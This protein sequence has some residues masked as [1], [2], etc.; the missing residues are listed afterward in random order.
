ML[1]K[2]YLKEVASSIDLINDYSSEMQIGILVEACNHL[3]KIISFRDNYFVAVQKILFGFES[4][5]RSAFYG[6]SD[7]VLDKL[8]QFTNSEW[9][10]VEFIM[11][12]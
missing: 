7:L 9:A 5:E 2:N 4:D 1:L 10:E 12:Q 3:I 6:I 11:M 8:N